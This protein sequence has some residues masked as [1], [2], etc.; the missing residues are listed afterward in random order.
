MAGRGDSLQRIKAYLPGLADPGKPSR[1]NRAF[2]QGRALT[3]ARALCP[4]SR[5]GWDAK[6]VP[7]SPSIGR[8]AWSPVRPTRCAAAV[9][10][11]EA[12]FAAD[13]TFRWARPDARG[14]A[15]AA[16]LRDLDR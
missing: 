6:N 4:C 11:G 16:R 1:S 7:P 8:P 10:G 9:A 12:A 13:F 2:F 5:A 14:E 3:A 15:R